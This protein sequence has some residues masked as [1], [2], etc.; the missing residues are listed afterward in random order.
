M[1]RIIL[2]ATGAVLALS[3]TVASAYFTG[4]AQVADSVVRA[5][6]VSV[7]A[8]PTSAALSIDALA[9]GG[10]QS[11]TLAVRNTGSL[12]ADFV[13]TAA[14][15]A[16]ITEFYN[17]LTCRVTKGESVLFEGPLTALRT[18]PVALAPG[19]QG[20]LRFTLGLPATAGNELAE[21]YVRLTLY[22]DAEQVH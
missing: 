22:I 16:G 2:F 18:A 12:P 13:V 1:R 15:K 6:A 5:G 19:E 14:K 7:S 10:T 4:Q 21:D 11:R 17:A 3:L 9:P 8:E 20:V